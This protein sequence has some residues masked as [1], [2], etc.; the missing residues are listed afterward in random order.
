MHFLSGFKLLLMLT[1]LQTL[2]LPEKNQNSSETRVVKCKGQSNGNQIQCLSDR[3]VPYKQQ[4][5]NRTALT[6]TAL[7]E[8]QDR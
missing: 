5:I 7:L 8:S 6:E 1:A 4:T 3:V 2:E